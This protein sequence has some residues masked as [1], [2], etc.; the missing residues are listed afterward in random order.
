MFVGQ[1]MH[2]TKQPCH[3]QFLLQ[4]HSVGEWNLLLS[5]T[6]ELRITIS[7]ATG[8]ATP[9]AANCGCCHELYTALLVTVIFAGALLVPAV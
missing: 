6:A 3:E 8:K 1:Y 4:C 5:H 9:G 2:V 7:S